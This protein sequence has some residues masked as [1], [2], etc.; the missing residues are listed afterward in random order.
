MCKRN[1]NILKINHELIQKKEE[2]TQCR[3][4]RSLS[5]HTFEFENIN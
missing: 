5:N 3:L 4:G 2:E 1:L